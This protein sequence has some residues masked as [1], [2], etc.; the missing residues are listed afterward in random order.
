M[1]EPMTP[2]TG[3]NAWKDKVKELVPEKIRSNSVV[4]PALAAPL[5]ENDPLW[6]GRFTLEIIGYVC[7]LPFT[8]LAIPSFLINEIIIFSCVARI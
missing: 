7:V 8:N 2:E 5:D 4:E 1:D 6:H 3:R